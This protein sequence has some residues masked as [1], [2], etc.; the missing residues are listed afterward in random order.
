MTRRRRGEGENDR[1]LI[2]RYGAFCL[3]YGPNDRLERA[4][5]ARGLKPWELA[6]KV[7]ISRSSLIFFVQRERLLSRCRF[8]T[9]LKIAEALD[10]PCEYFFDPDERLAERMLERG[11]PDFYDIYSE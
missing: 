7:S 8:E 3:G 6:N 4:M 5:E 10:V 11:R 9:V 1:L 2:S